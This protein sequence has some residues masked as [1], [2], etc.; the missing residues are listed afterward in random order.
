MA[1]DSNREI[2]TY[3]VTGVDEALI[4]TMR[5]GLV[6]KLYQGS[7]RVFDPSK[8]RRGIVAVEARD[9]PT[10]TATIRPYD[11]TLGGYVLE[12]NSRVCG[13]I[14]ECMYSNNLAQ[15]INLRNVCND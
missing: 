9:D 10:L 11:A 2:V 12:G 5:L 13:K 15:G 8:V 14:I 7:D 6:A 4:Q 1:I 3:N